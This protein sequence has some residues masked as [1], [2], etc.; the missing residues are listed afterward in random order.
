MTDAP[1]LVDVF[2]GTPLNTSD[3][4]FVSCVLRQTI[5][6]GPCFWS[7]IPTGKESAVQS[8]VE[9]GSPFWNQLI[10]YSCTELLVRSLAG[11]F[12]T[13]L[14]PSRS[15][16]KQWLDAS[17]R[18]AYY[19]KQTAYRAWC[20]ACNAD[21]WGRFVLA[22]SEAKRVYCVA[23]ESHKECTRNTVKP[24]ICLLKWWETQNVSIFGVKLSIPAHWGPGDDGV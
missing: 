10:H 6:E 23:W 2:V 8:G 1:D 12:K 14:L 13:T 5:S 21:H 7:I 19:A 24:S 9:H 11:I 3:H 18:I 15:V 22:R 4:C 16:D 17:C 20:R